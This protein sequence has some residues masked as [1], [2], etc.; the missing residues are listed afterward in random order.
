[1]SEEWRIMGLDVYDAYTNMAIDEAI[2]RE[3]SQGRSPNTIRLYRWKPSAV[4]IGYFQLVDQEVDVDACKRLGVDI[5]RRMTG[6]GAVYHAYEGEVTYSIIVNENHDRMPKDIIKSYELICGGIVDALRGLGMQTATF[7]PV[8]D[9]DVNGKKISGNAQ[10]RRWG[11]VVQHGTVLVD[12]DIRTM[13]TVLKVSKEKISDK[14]IKS[15][16]DR[17]T[18]IQ[19]EIGRRVSFEEVADAL[20]AALPKVFDVEATPSSLTVEEKDLAERLKREKYNTHGW[21]YDRPN[22]QKSQIL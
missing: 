18:T 3:R 16:E 11:V 17:V 10:T 19:R 4:S 13:F 15:V 21:L 12:T 20:K 2:C 6:G 9:I 1:M 8:N 14:L 22:K 7:R 5:V